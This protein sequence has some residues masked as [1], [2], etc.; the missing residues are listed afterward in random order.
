[1]T[2]RGEWPSGMGACSWPGAAVGKGGSGAHS[3]VPTW[4]CDCHG[5]GSRHTHNDTHSGPCS[6]QLRL[7]DAHVGA[8]LERG[9]GLS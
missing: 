9:R 6:G 2:A 3:L 5:Q 8:G 4:T 7:H 1:M